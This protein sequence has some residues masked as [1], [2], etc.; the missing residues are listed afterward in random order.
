MHRFDVAF[1]MLAKM[2][3]KFNANSPQGALPVSDGFA[4]LTLS[5]SES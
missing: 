1:E 5:V 2:L 4:A 3:A